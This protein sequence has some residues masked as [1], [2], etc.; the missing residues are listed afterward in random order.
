[1]I[2]YNVTVN[3]E[4]DVREEWLQ[5]MRELHIPEVMATGYFLEHK[6]CKVLVDEEQG[7]TYSIQYTCK[8]MQDYQEYQTKHA[9]QLQ[10]EVKDKYGDKFVAFRTLLEVI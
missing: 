3:I 6:I 7:T 10:K 2:I 8:N 1:M 9:P 4:N 5:W